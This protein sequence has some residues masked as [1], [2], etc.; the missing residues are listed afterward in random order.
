GAGSVTGENKPLYVVDGVPRED[1]S[2]LNQDQIATIDV[3]K[4]AS[5]TALYGSRGANGV[6]LVTTKTDGG[7]SYIPLT[8]TSRREVSNE[9]FVETPQSIQSNNKSS[10]I[11]FKETKL[12]SAFE[13][14]AVPLLSEHAFLIGKLGD[15]YK[16]DL[17]DG[18][19]NIYLENSYVGKSYIN[20]EQFTDTLELSFGVDNNI[21]VKREKLTDFSQSQF[22]GTNRKVTVA[23][24][25]SIRNNKTYPVTAK[26]TDQV[27]VSTIKEIQVE[28]IDLTGGMLN[29]DT[30]EVN[31]ELELK[32]NETIDLI[33]KYSVKYPK[34][35]K[36]IID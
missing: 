34:D 36:V 8:I 5:A 12:N 13:Y 29:N 21:S 32:P 33:I 35:K 27:P 19:A 11:V 23:Y 10:T 17:L 3:L 24:K 4:D 26:I 15:W 9:Y 2:Y 7:D 16:T 18:E 25:I 6:I 22:I 1:I 14:Q 30:G 28:T 20:T 31:W